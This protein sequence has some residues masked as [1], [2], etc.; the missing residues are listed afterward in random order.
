[1][2]HL[3]PCR[4]SRWHDGLEHYCRAGKAVVGLIRRNALFLLALA[5]LTGWG[6]SHAWPS[7][8]WLTVRHVIA[9]DGPAT[10]PVVMDVNRTIQ[11]A[12]IADWSV[13]IRRWN[14][15]RWVVYCAANGGG[16]YRPDADLP[17]PVTLDWWTNG[18]CTTPVQGRY[19]ISTVWTIRGGALP[20]KVVRAESNV[21]EVLP[22][23]PAQS[24]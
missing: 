16:E 24:N 14:G 21:F 12:F 10:A 22:P 7:S 1:M 3:H 9:F 13:L 20:D 17:D 19:L 4:R 8:W 6:V 15:A 2:D 23:K 5:W 11:R 18:Q